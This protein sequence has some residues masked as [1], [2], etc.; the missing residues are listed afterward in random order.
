[1]GADDKASNKIDDLGGKAKE[2]VGKLTG[3]KDTESEGKVDQAKSSLKDAGE[4]VKDAF[5]K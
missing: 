2:G 5:K 4:K 1:M 3:D